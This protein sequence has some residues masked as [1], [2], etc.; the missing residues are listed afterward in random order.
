MVDS[1]SEGGLDAPPTPGQPLDH[2]QTRLGFKVWATLRR[3]SVPTPRAPVAGVSTLF[4][5]AA[6]MVDLAASIRIGSQRFL[7]QSQRI[8]D[9]EADKFEMY[10]LANIASLHVDG[11]RSTSLVEGSDD[12]AAAA[13]SEDD[14][15]A[16][17]AD[18]LR[19]LRAAER[20]HRELG[21]EMPDAAP[22]APLLEELRANQS[23]V[24][25]TEWHAKWNAELK[26]CARRASAAAPARRHARRAPQVAQ[27]LLG[28]HERA[29]RAARPR[30][31][32]RRG[33][34]AARAGRG[35]PNGVC[36]C[37]H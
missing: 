30:G 35:G 24:L 19:R 17:I 29:G 32:R 10:Y 25:S 20:R 33:V 1:S 27:A 16:E 13:E 26:R 11:R 6:A 18:L 36:P 14:V 7:A 21:G 22:T 28:P 8:F 15:D 4:G 23:E 5:S 37:D 31:R 3:G 2:E 12:G 9:E 34:R